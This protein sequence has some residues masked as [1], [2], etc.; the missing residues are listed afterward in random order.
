MILFTFG[1]FIG[2]GMG[3]TALLLCQTSADHTTA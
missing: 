1:V 2:A 3:V